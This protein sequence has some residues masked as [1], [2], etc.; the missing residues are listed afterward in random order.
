MNIKSTR[1]QSSSS[2]TPDNNSLDLLNHQLGQKDIDEVLKWCFEEFGNK[3][4]LG[5][6]FGLSGVILIHKIAMLKLPIKVFTLDTGLLF[7]ETYEL[8]NKLESEYGVEIETVTP[9]LT[10]EGQ[11][12]LYESKL[13]EKDPDQCC[14]LRKVLPLK[15][16][17]MNKNGWITGLRRSQTATRK[18]ISIV[19]WD[20]E[21][22]VIKIN[23]LAH[24][25]I[26]KVWDYIQK[27]SLPYNPLH[28]EGYPSIGCFP[29][30]SKATSVED[31]RSG[32]WANLDKTECGIHFVSPKK[33]DNKV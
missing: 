4:V 11:A 10:L 26:E 27:H 25:S 22:R 1:D 19:E 17:L 6:A 3:I 14:Y 16:Y 8:W 28:D 7:K 32:R 33:G 18:N 5:T 15:K 9:I 12:Q 31:E 23:P 29:C 21:N 13:W 24:W 20:T 2:L 30:T